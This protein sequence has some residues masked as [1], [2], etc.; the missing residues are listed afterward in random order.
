MQRFV[1]MKKEGWWSGDLHIHRPPAEI[2]LLMRAED[3]HI[4][5][6]MTWWNNQN[7]WQGQAAAREAARAIR[8]RPVLSPAWPARTNAKAARCCISI[9]RSRCR[10]P[11]R[12]A[13]IPRRSNSWNRPGRRDGVHV[14]VEKPFWW[15]MPVWVATG[16]ID[17]MGLANNHQHRDGMLDDEAWGK[18]RDKRHVSLA[19]TATAAGRS[20]STISC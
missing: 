2:E 6:V 9:C 14:D 8:R 11:A 10:S 7:Q 4:G 19:R 5:P 15:D 1:D 20:T 18:P 16:K 17:S 12:S 13:N 3:L